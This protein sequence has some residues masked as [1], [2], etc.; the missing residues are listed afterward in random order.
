MQND[1]DPS[2]RRTFLSR[3]KW[4][5]N[6]SPAKDRRSG[7]FATSHTQLAKGEKVTIKAS[8]PPFL[9]QVACKI[10]FYAPFFVRDIERSGYYRT[11]YSGKN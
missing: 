5:A 3:G 6:F 4:E 1:A 7:S 9:I 10:F 2:R 11:C 8:I